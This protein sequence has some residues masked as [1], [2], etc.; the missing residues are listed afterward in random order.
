MLPKQFAVGIETG[1]DALSSLHEHVASFRIHSRAGSGIALIDCIAEKIVVETL[2]KFF[3]GL[4]IEAGYAFLHVRSLAQ[5][6][7]DIKLS[8]GND[9]SGLTGEI[10]DPKRG[11]F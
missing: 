11:F 3:A 5:V 9:G 1:K 4:G 10:G 2:P 7:H 6:A 8:V